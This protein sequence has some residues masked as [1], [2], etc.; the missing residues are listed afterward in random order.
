MRL[1]VGAV[2]VV[3]AAILGAWWMLP[4]EAE[5]LPV[6][7]AVGGVSATIAGTTI[8]GLA[9]L[10]LTVVGR[11]T[12]HQD[13]FAHLWPAVYAKAVFAGDGVFIAFRDTINRYRV[14]VDDAP[15][16]VVTVTRPGDAVIRLTG[17]GPGPHALR[18]EKISE[19]FSDDGRV[20]GVFV[21][22][23]GN[24]RPAPQLLDRQIMFIGDS[25]TVGLGNLSK[26]RDCRGDDVFRLTDTTQS[27]GPRVARHFDADYQMIA[28]SGIG[29]I[30]NYDGV[31][32]GTGMVA[33]Y[34]SGGA[35]HPT[36]QPD[37]IV[38]TLGSNDLGGD[39][40]AEEQWAD[41]EA[42]T[43][44][45]V[46]Q[47][48]RFLTDMGAA[49]PGAQFILLTIANFGPGYLTAHEAVMVDLPDGIAS[50]T[51]LRAVPAMTQ[52]GCGWHPSPS[53]HRMIADHLIAYL[54]DNALLP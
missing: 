16:H 31:S 11:T 14:F 53:D 9:P 27:F 2:V 54:S 51:H 40:S 15:A 4:G 12:K 44:D 45:F 47:Y 5:D 38:V 37:L 41:K 22:D 50:R 35:D 13:G 8:D 26:S 3:I 25:D 19:S 42:L 21:A 36:W 29:L 32:P 6:V 23:P 39:L 10:E 34:G 18:I 48:R 33:V 49:Y 30:R 17:F 43:A 52:E 1:A 46:A 28:R 24:T 7:E 20:L